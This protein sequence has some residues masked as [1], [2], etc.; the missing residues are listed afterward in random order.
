MTASPCAVLDQ[1][2]RW[3]SERHN[4]QYGATIPHFDDRTYWYG[5]SPADKAVTHC[6]RVCASFNNYPSRVTLLKD[7]DSDLQ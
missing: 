3:E 6:Q 5:I 4:L 2:L 1:R 7:I